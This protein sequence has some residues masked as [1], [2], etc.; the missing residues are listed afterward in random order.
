MF[1]LLDILAKYTKDEYLYVFR[2]WQKK[3]G[4]KT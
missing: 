4:Y 2:L 1:V 3:R